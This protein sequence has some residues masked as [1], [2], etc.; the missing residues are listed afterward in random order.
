MDVFIFVIKTR[1]WDEDSMKYKCI[2][3]PWGW[4]RGRKRREGERERGSMEERGEGRKREGRD[5]PCQFYH[6][7]PYTKYPNLVWLHTNFKIGF[8]QHTYTIES[9]SIMTSSLCMFPGNGDLYN[10]LDMF[11]WKYQL[12]ISKYLVFTNI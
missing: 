9:R 7:L 1:K 5:F 3:G 2:V 6:N 4:E 10:N 8:I 11:V 12:E